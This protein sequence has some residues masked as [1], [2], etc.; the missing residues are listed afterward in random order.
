MKISLTGTTTFIGPA[1]IG[2][3]LDSGHHIN[4][5]VKTD[6]PHD[7][8]DKIKNIAGLKKKEDRLSFHAGN[9]HSTDSILNHLKDSDAAVCL[10]DLKNTGFIKN[11]LTAVSRS[12]VKRV[13]F[14]G[15]TTVLVP[16]DSEI[17]KAKLL[18]EEL[19]KKSGLDFTILRPSMIY[20]TPD[21]RNFSKMISFINKRGFFVVFGRGD[22]LIQPV[23]VEDVAGAIAAVIEKPATFGKTYEIPG[24]APLKYKEML[25]IVKSKLDRQFRIYYLPIGISRIAV[26]LYSRLVPSSSLKPDMIDRMEIDKAYSYENASEDFGYEPMPF[27]TG[28]EKF[29]KH[30]EKN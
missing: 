17:K 5:L 9:L 15:S 23:H 22:N 2:R 30:L 7:K 14:I 10:V 26:K 3:L 6:T 12:A 21:D 1:V 11:I 20:G 13:I 28:I 18:S 8:I 4:C 29:I 19:I 25:E 16:F 24:R 27:E